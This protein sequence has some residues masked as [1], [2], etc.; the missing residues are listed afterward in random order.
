MS[1]KNLHVLHTILQIPSEN[2]KLHFDINVLVSAC[3]K[4]HE[5]ELC[6]TQQHDKNTIVVFYITREHAVI[7]YYLKSIFII[8]AI[9][10]NFPDTLVVKIY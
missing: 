4:T 10:Y 6:I 7:K 3:T 1:R 9:L 8:L 2:K 5:T